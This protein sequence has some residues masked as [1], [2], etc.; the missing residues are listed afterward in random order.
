MFP[1][2]SMSELEKISEITK[3][4][5]ISLLKMNIHEYDGDIKDKFLF[6]LHKIMVEK[7]LN[8]LQIKGLE[9]NEVFFLS[10]LYYVPRKTRKI[11]NFAEKY[12]DFYSQFQK[13]N[14]LS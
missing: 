1:L 12:H 11:I 9:I 13:L 6:K 7:Y 10:D 3:S 8:S 5:L 4:K 14:E 2:K